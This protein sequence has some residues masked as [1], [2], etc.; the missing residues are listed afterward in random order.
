M[1]GLEAEQDV[2]GQLVQ[3][4]R[5]GTWQ[6]LEVERD[7]GNALVLLA[8]PELMSALRPTLT[9]CPTRRGASGSRFRS[10]NMA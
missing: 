10:K 7:V 3:H 1:A 9:P 6:R 2:L 5:R 4:H 8:L